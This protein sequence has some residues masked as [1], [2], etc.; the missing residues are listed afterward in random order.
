LYPV[1]RGRAHACAAAPSIPRAR[2]LGALVSSAFALGGGLLAAAPAHAADTTAPSVAFRAPAPGG[3][4]SG[5]YFNNTAISATATDDV[6]VDHVDF[7]ADGQFV[8][9]ERSAP[10]TGN[11]DTTT[12]PDGRHT[13]T[14]TAF[15]AAGNSRSASVEVEV[16]NGAGPTATWKAPTNGQVVSGNLN[17]GTACEATATSPG[18]SVRKVEF[19]LDGELLNTE[20]SAPYTCYFDTRK[21]ADGAHVLGAKVTDAAGKVS[22][23]SITVTV[24]NGTTTPQPDPD[25]M[26]DPPSRAPVIAAVGDIACKPGDPYFNGGKGTSAYCRQMATSDLVLNK[27]LAKVLALGDLQYDDG[28][29]SDFRGSYDPSWGR[30][31][32]ITAPVPGNHEYRTSG[33]SGYY[34]YFGSLAGERG[35]GYYSF[36]LGSWHLIALNSNIARDSGSEQLKWLERDL[37]ANASKKCVLA[38]WHHPRFSAGEYGANTSVQPFWKT[39]YD[40]GAD[41]VLAGHDHGYQRFA[42]LNAS[43]QKDAARGIRSFVSGAGGRNHYKMGS[44]SLREAANDDTF[45]VLMMTLRDGGYDWR[46]QPEAGRSWTDK[47]TSSCH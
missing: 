32:S 11:W 37:A 7:F 24:R 2:R 14:A 5:T 44:S 29:L 36:D 12:V 45:G 31:K 26:P 20:V 43:G 38:Y 15:D 25:P 8:N 34:D 27:G 41:V 6:G 30:V 23:S 40:A 17:G 1:S 28:R 10:Y 21:V 9:R 18:S 16:R 3:V 13:L 22:T 39:L 35:K 33:A 42:P 19:L 4:V 46:F 47:G